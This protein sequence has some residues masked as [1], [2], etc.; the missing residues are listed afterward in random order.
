MHDQKVIYTKYVEIGRVVF[1][2]DGPF[3]GKL[4]AIVNI[5]DG[6]RI[7]IDGP[8]TGVKRSIIN[9]KKIVLTK[10]KIPLR[11]GQRTGNVQKAFEASGVVEAFNQTNWA[12]KIAAKEKRS[13]LND[14]ERYKVMRIKQLKNRIITHEYNRLKK[15]ANKANLLFISFIFRVMVSDTKYYDILEIS[16]NATEAEIKKAYRKTALKYHPDKNPDGAEKFKEVS[17]AYE[18]L[19][20]PQKR[21][22]YDKYGEE[23]LKEGG[24]GGGGEGFDHAFDIFDMMFGGGR[25][26][27]HKK[28]KAED[29]HF[30][31]KVTLKELY[32]GSTRKLKVKRKVLCKKCKGVGGKNVRACTSCNGKG[33]KVKLVQVGPGMV[34]QS[35]EACRQCDRTGELFDSRCT[36]CDGNKLQ[37]VVE[38][39]DITIEKGMKDGEKIVVSGKGTEDPKLE[40]G[41]FIVRL[42]QEEDKIWERKDDTL[43]IEQKLDLVEALCGCTKYIKTLDGRLLSYDLIPGE[44]VEP[45]SL[46]LIRNEGMPHRRNP[47]DKGNLLILF[48]VTFPKSINEDKVK[49]LKEL[50]PPSEKSN[51]PKEAE[52]VII[53]DYHITGFD[54]QAMEDEEECHHGQSAPQCAAQ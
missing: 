3:K 15:A 34:T 28:T 22:V 6:N 2:K 4:A 37:S 27:R 11:V 46:K 24:M 1:I 30:Q 12:K 33:I 54:N 35:Q 18:V 39:I 51:I 40:T 26:G 41:D 25:G 32:S 49:I 7:L 13:K 19:S 45:R 38:V 47:N 44:V 36:E 50:L 29:L 21:E 52:A 17:A 42:E 48:D 8:T 14:F 43:I 23:G 10:F 16:P 53:S 31:L 5:V 9:I 20:D